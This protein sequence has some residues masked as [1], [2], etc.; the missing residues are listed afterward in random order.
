VTELLQEVARKSFLD[1]MDSPNHGVILTEV[2]KISTR[3]TRFDNFHRKM[4]ISATGRWFVGCVFIAAALKTVCAQANYEPYAIRTFV[5]VP[6]R[7]GSADGTGTLPAVFLVPTAV[8]V[9]GAGNVYVAD[10]YN[11]TIRTVTP[12]GVVNTLAGS[13]RLSGSA[14]GTGSAARF[15]YPQALALDSTG[16]VYVA[17]TENHTI[18]KITSA[19]V[20]TTF[21]GTPGLSGSADGTVRIEF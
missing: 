4:K 10:T 13:A 5:G 7:S 6:G 9:D 19:G 16:N 14:D 21:A 8:A 18:R 20:V 11:H 15:S 17:D 1:W 3:V 2:R 12:G